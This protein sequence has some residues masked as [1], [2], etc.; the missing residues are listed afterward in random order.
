MKHIKLNQKKGFLP[1]SHEDERHFSN[2]L[3]EYAAKPT[4]YTLDG[5][6]FTRNMAPSDIEDLA[7][8]A[9]QNDNELLPDCCF[10]ASRL[11]RHRQEDTCSFFVLMWRDKNGRYMQELH[12][13]N[14]TLGICLVITEELR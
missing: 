1:Y 3:L 10:I 11:I 12:L 14:E 7:Q 9:Q 5:F 8:M 4:A 6:T 13:P 2:E